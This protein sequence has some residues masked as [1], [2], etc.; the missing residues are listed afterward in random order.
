M[1]LDR[2]QLQRPLATTARKE[3]TS[4][5][6]PKTSKERTHLSCDLRIGLSV[7]RVVDLSRILRVFRR[8]AAERLLRVLQQQVCVVVLVRLLL[9]ARILL[10]GF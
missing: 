9:V 4:G 7:P 1:T 8:T 5:V 10:D 6:A 2:C 3:I